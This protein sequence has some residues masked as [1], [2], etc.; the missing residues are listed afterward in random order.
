VNCPQFE[1]AHTRSKHLLLQ[2]KSGCLE[3][4]ISRYRN[5]STARPGSIPVDPAL[6]LF[7]RTRLR[8]CSRGLKFDHP[9]ALA[10]AGVADGGSLTTNE[11]GFYRPCWRR[12]DGY[13]ALKYNGLYDP[14][15]YQVD[16]AC[17]MLCT[18]VE[19]LNRLLSS[20]SLRQCSAHL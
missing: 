2:L 1:N 9:P 11:P 13:S 15:L 4:R 10:P 12:C 17:T 3:N 16:G 18:R 8:S 6:E 20:P 19:K 5:G 14:L 7:P